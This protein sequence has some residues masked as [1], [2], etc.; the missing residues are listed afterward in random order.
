[1]RRPAPPL[2]LAAALVALTAAAAPR[3]DTLAEVRERG[4]VRCGVAPALAGFSSADSLGEYSGFDVELCRALAAAVLGEAEAIEAV[5]VSAAE[6]FDA[7]AAGAFDVLARSTPWTLANNARAEFAGIGFHDGQAFMTR[8]RE[9]LR[10][11]LEL[12]DRRV[13]VEL[14]T[15]DELHAADFFVASELRYRP[16]YL[17]D[18]DAAF[19]AYA[20][21]EC[22]AIT[23]ARSTLAARRS[24][25]SDAD[26]HVILPELISK[27]PRGPVVRNDDPAWEN[28]VRWTLACMIDAEE[29]GV[30]S[31][32][33]ARAGSAPTP[34]IARLLGRDDGGGGAALGLEPDWCADVLRLVGNYGEVYERHVGPDTPLGL[35]RGIN[36]LWTDG[37]LIHAPPIR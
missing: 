15:D 18:R 16:V 28:V 33:A 27:D 22:T 14:G 7:L 26:A 24:E 10:S 1:M 29:L 2:A 17:E 36:A 13:C 25:L 21:D 34:A 8:R 31:V 12:D 23:T 5:P 37:G 20:R 35:E 30:S 11:A 4:A 9:A 3:A 19:A 6:R 32:E